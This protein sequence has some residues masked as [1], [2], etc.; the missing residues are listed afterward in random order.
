M[1]KRITEGASRNTISK[2]ITIL[3]SALLLAKRL[4]MYEGEPGTLRPRE[5][6]NAYKP[7]DRRLTP[8]QAQ[9][10]VDETNPRWRLHVA[11]YIHTGVR[12]SELYQ[13]LP[14]HVDLGKNAVWVDGTKTDGAPRWVSLSCTARD[15][16]D[17]LMKNAKPGE[18]LFEFWAYADRDI[19]VACRKAKIPEVSHNDFR[20]TFASLMAS[21]GVP[22]QHCAKLLGHKSLDMVT[23]VYARLSPESL[24]D[25]VNLLPDLR[26]EPAV[27]TS[28]A[29]GSAEGS[30]AGGV[31]NTCRK[32]TVVSSY[33]TDRNAKTA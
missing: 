8:E 30:V 16:V 24:Q 3:V 12:K 31:T 26:V 13:I 11:F 29:S 4:G 27:A 32:T 19:R 33:A 21:A 20:R 17:A 18:R 10:L 5:L 6:K 28:P 9:K 15:V 7:R 14:E 23:R 1:D 2:E 25:A 22:L